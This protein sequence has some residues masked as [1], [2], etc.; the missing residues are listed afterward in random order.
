MA[1]G[2]HPVAGDFISAGD[3]LPVLN[4]FATWVEK[5]Y[6]SLKT[7]PSLPPFQFWAKGLKKNLILGSLH[8]SSDRMGRKFP[9][10]FIGTGT[11]KQWEKNW[12][13]LP[14]MGEKSWRR[15]DYMACRRYADLRSLQTDTTAIP[16]PEPRLSRDAMPPADD[17]MP[18]TAPCYPPMD[19]V[20]SQ[21]NQK[22]SAAFHMEMDHQPHPYDASGHMHSLLKKAMGPVVPNAVFTAQT[23]GKLSM[24]VFTHPL[25]VE[26]FSSIIHSVA[27]DG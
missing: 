11:L 25:A 2:K 22:G 6:Q 15:I 19:N 12:E 8:D 13:W 5:G 4:A 1:F 16:A 10:M 27:L 20:L 26:D 21:L 14:W 23:A 24:V 7:A 17:A 18:P 9:L 3:S